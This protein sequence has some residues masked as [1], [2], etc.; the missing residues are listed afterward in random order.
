MMT[1]ALS[2]VQ[3]PIPGSPLCRHVTIGSPV[4]KSWTMRSMIQKKNHTGSSLKHQH[5]QFNHVSAPV[6]LPLILYSVVV[7]RID[8][9]ANELLE[10]Q[11]S[12]E[13]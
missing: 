6:P 2:E 11:D 3:F 8:L 13:L 4:K 1:I 7:C 10:I 9:A 12:C 5:I